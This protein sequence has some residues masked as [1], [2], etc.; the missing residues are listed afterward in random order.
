MFFG[1]QHDTAHL[2]H[3]LMIVRNRWS[4]VAEYSRIIYSKLCLH[5]KLWKNFHLAWRNNRSMCTVS[6]SSRCT[7]E[8]LTY[9]WIFFHRTRRKVFEC[10]DRCLQKSFI[11]FVRIGIQGL[12][13]VCTWIWA[14]VII[15]SVMHIEL[16]SQFLF[17]IVRM[18]V[19][20]FRRQRRTPED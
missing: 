12:Q 16:T 7:N 1:T 14:A 19:G 15:K 8:C 5:A 4:P 6:T 11:V 20:F 17:T 10:I 13:Q 3:I 2:L 18:T 9:F